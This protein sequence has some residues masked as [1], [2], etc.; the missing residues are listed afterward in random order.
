MKRRNLILGASGTLGIGAVG[1]YVNSRG[2]YGDAPQQ[3]STSPAVPARNPR[4][5]AALTQKTLILIEL[6]GGNDGLNTVVPFRD[7][8]YRSLRPNLAIP[9]DSVIPLTETLGFNP[10]FAPL[11]SIWKENQ[12]SIIQGVGYPQP[13]RSHFQSIDLWERGLDPTMPESN[14]GW[15][16]RAFASINIPGSAYDMGGIVIGGSD[17]L[18]RGGSLPVLMVENAKRLKRS[19]S[20]TNS[21]PL[22]AK[23]D[24][25]PALTHILSVEAELADNTRRLVAALQNAPEIS[26]S[27]FPKGTTGRKFHTIALLLGSGIRPPVIKLSITGFDTHT[28]QHPRHTKAVAELG[29]GLGA[30][31]KVLKEQSIWSDT[32]VLTY[33]EFGRRVK[34]NGSRGT[35]HGAASTHFLLGGSVRGGFQG[36][37]PRLDD[38]DGNGDLQ[39]AI[40]YRSIYRTVTERFWSLP[41]P[42]PGSS[43][44]PLL[45]V[46]V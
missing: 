32:A 1:L 2:R 40:D 18:L 11:H 46:F 15:V 41:R 25:N 7:P 17:E 24:G 4:P 36:P 38:L 6:S 28:N 27:S 33:S 14:I 12:L 3:T 45:D 20:R 29:G 5:T 10:E 21:A 35:D 9:E 44:H 8:L 34:E 30:L 39:Y 22:P 19:A 42:A 43:N 37:A 16:A 31:V 13:N 23:V 26:R